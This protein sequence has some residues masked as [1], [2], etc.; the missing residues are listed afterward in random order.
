MILI[1]L[2]F[3]LH[4]EFLIMRR[5]ALAA[6]A[7]FRFREH[8]RFRRT[9]ARMDSDLEEILKSLFAELQHTPEKIKAN[10]FKTFPDSQ[11]RFGSFSVEHWASTHST[12]SINCPWEFYVRTPHEPKPTQ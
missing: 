11:A 9:L 5:F 2:G 8:G 1:R 12:T 4:F 10:I 7:G 6:V 3:L